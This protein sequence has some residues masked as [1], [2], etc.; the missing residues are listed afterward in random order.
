MSYAEQF[1]GWWQATESPPKDAPPAVLEAA[2]LH[3]D[4][5]I[6][7]I[8][9]SALQYASACLTENLPLGEVGKQFPKVVGAIGV[10]SHRYCTG[11]RLSQD[12][13]LTA[14][15][16]FMD[17]DEGGY[18][19]NLGDAEIRKRWFEYRSDEPF[20][21]SVCGIERAGATG[22]YEHQSDFIVVRIA[23]P[24]DIPPKVTLTPSIPLW[25]L[26]FYTPGLNLAED[27]NYVPFKPK[28]TL[29]SGCKLVATAG[30]CMFHGC[31]TLPGMS[32]APMFMI[33]AGGNATLQLGGIHLIGHRPQDRV[34]NASGQLAI[35]R[36][37]NVGLAAAVFAK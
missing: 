20:R 4:P 22:P 2:A 30:P 27:Q 13:V 1:V 36:A 33:D 16:C 24:V 15:H 32:G 8:W 37:P 10:E 9:E 28:S 11:T 14:R 26:N 5:K 18:Q 19:R 35:G 29:V 21:Y 3:F 31:Q 12:L 7:L 17:G 23:K 34:C 6:R 25:G